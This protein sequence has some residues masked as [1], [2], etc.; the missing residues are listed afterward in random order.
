MAEGGNGERV[1]G[2]WLGRLT[3]VTENWGRTTLI[4]RAYEI[5]SP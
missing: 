5:F 3:G 1:F 4:E 2:G